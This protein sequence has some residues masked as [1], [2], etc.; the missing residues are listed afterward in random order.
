[1]SNVARD[2]ATVSATDGLFGWMLQYMRPYRRRV[3]LLAVLLASEIGLGA[4][5]PWPMAV[6]FDQVFGL[7]VH[8]LVIHA[9]VV[10]YQVTVTGH[11]G[12][13]AAWS[14]TG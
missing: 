4:L 10:L 7:P 14:T 5:Q 3:A 11:A 12:A 13:E 8:V 1:M 2:P 6:V 9:V